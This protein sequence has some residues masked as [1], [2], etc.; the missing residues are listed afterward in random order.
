MCNH[1]GSALTPSF[2]P[3]PA[4]LSL[5]LA[6]SYSLFARLPFFPFLFLSLDPVGYSSSLESR[7]A[8]APFRSPP[9]RRCAS[10]ELP[11]IEF[12]CIGPTLE[13]MEI[14]FRALSERRRI[15]YSALTDM[16][17][18]YR[19]ALVVSLSQPEK[20]FSLHRRVQFAHVR[21]IRRTVRRVWT[22]I[23]SAA[24]AVN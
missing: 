20:S 2:A 3:S 21:R 4:P 22:T 5:S 9:R 19:T 13:T 23:I 11:V 15:L 12:F 1:R 24:L 14:C 16:V 17:R 6:R 10:G 7:A 8:A 18:A